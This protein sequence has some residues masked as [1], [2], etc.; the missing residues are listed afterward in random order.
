MCGSNCQFSLHAPR[1]P[2]RL[3]TQ[4]EAAAYCR[5]SIPD[6][7]Y[8]VA[9]K[10]LPPCL[11]ILLLWDKVAIDRAIDKLSGFGAPEPEAAS[12]MTDLERFKAERAVRKASQGQ[13]RTGARRTR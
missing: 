8:L 12:G 5:K 3:L 11:P 7:E 4:S 2:P 13:K 10:V 6:F 9:V 1:H